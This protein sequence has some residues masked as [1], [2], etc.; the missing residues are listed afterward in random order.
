MPEVTMIEAIRM[1]LS[2]AL[3]EHPDVVIFGEDV[4]IDGG[5]FRATDGLAQRYGAFRV[6]DTPL[7]ETVIAGMAVGA[8]A[9]GLRPV[10]EIQFMGFLYPALDQLA[11][12]AA[13]LRN[14]TRGRLTCPMVLRAPYDMCILFYYLKTMHLSSNRF[15]DLKETRTLL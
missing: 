14:R 2:R 3:E 4:G 10:A 9:H 1:A 8:A 7:S 11:N 6:R 5:V 15:S 12:H 13:R